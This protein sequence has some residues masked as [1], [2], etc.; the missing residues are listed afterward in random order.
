MNE[1]SLIRSCLQKIFYATNMAANDVASAVASHTLLP[2]MIISVLPY[3]LE[4]GMAHDAWLMAH[5]AWLMAHE[6]WLMAHDAWLMAH[7]ACMESKLSTSSLQQNLSLAW[8]Q[9]YIG[10]STI[11]YFKAY[12]VSTNNAYT[13]RVL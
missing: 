10:S 3:S 12:Y 1:S 13:Q 7:D 9:Q 2:C 8:N 11:Y 4:Y 5:E 6:V